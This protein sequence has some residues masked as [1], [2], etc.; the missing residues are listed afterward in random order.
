MVENSINTMERLLDQDDK[1]KVV[2]FDLTYNDSRAWHDQ[3]VVIALLCVRHHVLLYHHC[4]A[5]VPCGHFTRFI[6]SPDYSKKYMASH[7]DLVEA[8]IDPYYRGVKAE[9]GKNKP[10]WHTTEVH[11]GGHHQRS[12]G[13][14][15]I[16][17][18]LPESCRHPRQYKIW[19]GENKKQK[20][21][22]VDLVAT[23]IDPYDRDMKVE[24]NKD[25]ND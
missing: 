24:C 9:C 10:A 18:G 6:N 19:G 20:D 7:V 21:F 16:G 8:I 13:A 11:Y 15:D 3:K 1:Y 23:I 25:N 14:Q 4:M 12:K 2:V 17:F 22:L 5:T